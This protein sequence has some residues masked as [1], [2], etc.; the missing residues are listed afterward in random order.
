MS[1]HSTDYYRV[2]CKSLEPLHISLYFP[3]KVENTYSN[4]N[5]KN[6]NQYLLW[7]PSFFN[8]DY[9]FVIVVLKS[10]AFAN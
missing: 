5:F 4:L 9:S 6:E 2:P 7:P 8:L 1:H 3:R 10:E